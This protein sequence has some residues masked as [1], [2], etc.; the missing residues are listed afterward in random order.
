M[1]H[2]NEVFNKIH[3][4][5][6]FIDKINL[7]SG[8]SGE[9]KTFL[10]MVLDEYLLESGVS[11]SHFDSRYTNYSED[12][13]I[14]LC[15]NKDVVIFDNADLYLTQRILDYVFKNVDIFIISIKFYC[16]LRFDLFNFYAINYSGNSLVV[17]RENDL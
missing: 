1:L 3:F 5:V 14:S 9:G 12:Q 16:R 8:L 4:D 6:L 17:R 2:L 10:F 15:V 11:Y 7:F 13:L